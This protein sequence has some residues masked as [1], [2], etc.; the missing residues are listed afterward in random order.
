MKQRFEINLFSRVS[1]GFAV[2]VELSVLESAF[3]KEEG[4]GTTT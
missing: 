3:A 4:R 2:R 1:H